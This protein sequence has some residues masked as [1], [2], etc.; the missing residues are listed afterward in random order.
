MLR[1]AYGAAFCA[2]HI[3]HRPADAGLLHG[4]GGGSHILLRNLQHLLR[5]TGQFEAAGCGAEAVTGLG[6]AFLYAGARALLITHWEINSAVANVLVTDIFKRQAANPKLS[7]S[8]AMRR[9]KLAMIDGPGYLDTD[10]GS[11]FSYAH[12]VFWAP[13]ALF[14]EGAATMN[15]TPPKN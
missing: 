7:P 9:A 13:F 15:A 5:R 4:L 11:L 12:P 1:W 3:L 6:R 8:Q 14:G 2:A 10:G